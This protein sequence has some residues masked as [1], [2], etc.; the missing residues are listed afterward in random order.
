MN[1]L[2]PAQV[3][4][5]E[6][7]ANAAGTSYEEMMETA[8]RGCAEILLERYGD[9]RS[10][11]I[12]AG[13]GKNGGDGYVCARVLSNA[14]KAVTVIRVFCEPGDPLSERMR[15]RLPAAVETLVFQDAHDLCA[16]RIAGA[17][18]IVDAIFGIGFRGRFPGSVKA[19]VAL[20]DK[21]KAKRAAID[22]PSGLGEASEEDTPFRA[23]LTV[24]MYCLKNEHVFAPYRAFCG[25]TAVVPIGIPEWTDPVPGALTKKEAAALLPPRPYNANKGTFGNTLIFGGCRAMPGAGI[26]A[27]GGALKSGAGLVTVALPEENLPIAACAVPEC[28]FLPLGTDAEGFLK[29]ENSAVFEKNKHKYTAVVLG[30]GMGQTE[31]TR[32]LAAD[33]LK[34][35][36]CPVVLDAD[37]INAAAAHI[38]VLK[39]AASPVLLTPHPGEMSRLTGL[40]AGEINADRENVAA[41]FAKKHGV[42]VLLKG[43]TT[44]IASPDGRVY[45]NPTGST[46]LARGG[47]GDVLAGVIGAL[48]SQGTAPFEALCLGAYVH[49]LAGELSE[50][51]NTAYGATTAEN[52]RHLPPAFK[53]ILESK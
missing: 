18:V 44:V 23:E 16:E 35:S 33:V 27:A 41:A 34:M 19:A 21:A 51:E 5:A 40:S 49:G 12:L 31:E 22:L 45:L 46:A 32:A 48:L 50:K 47:S 42:F 24:S 4:A 3:R 38:D 13:K 6:N 15:Q 17:A 26:L 2:S 36:V 10:F 29:T 20:A 30:N 14:G 52:L 28:V 39:E 1:I 11:V 37:G 9:C 53:T 43:E 7:A 8:G 25:E